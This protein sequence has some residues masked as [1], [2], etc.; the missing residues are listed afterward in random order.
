LTDDLHGH[1]P[2]LCDKQGQSFLTIIS[3]LALCFYLFQFPLTAGY[4]VA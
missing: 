3:F 1:L 2:I 4:F